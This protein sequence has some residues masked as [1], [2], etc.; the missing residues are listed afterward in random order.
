[1]TFSRLLARRGLRLGLASLAALGIG[2]LAAMAQETAPLAGSEPGEARTVV[3]AVAG[4]EAWTDTGL[5]VASGDMVFFRAEG[6]ITLQKGNPE[7][8][9]GPGGYDLQTLQQPLTGRR[10]GSLIGK[11]VIGVTVLIDEQT[12]EE[13]REEAAVFFY[14]G[15]E[16]R[17]EMPAKGRLF[18]GINENVIGDNAGEFRVTV[19]A[20]RA[21]APL[22]AGD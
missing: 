11:V 22:S 3:V 15:A 21:R 20:P 1:V 9:C 8:E 5:E 18:L 16:S 2:A 13:R 17:V 4:A 6:K 7:A 14:V 19:T 10:L 12:K